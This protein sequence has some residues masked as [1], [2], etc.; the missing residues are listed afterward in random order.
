[1]IISC[2]SKLILT[3]DFEKSKIALALRARAILDFS[4]SLVRI[5]FELHSISYDF[6]Y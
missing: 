4:K 1:M 5:N 6:L 3:R 2:N